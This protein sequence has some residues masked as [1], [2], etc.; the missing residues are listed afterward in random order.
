MKHGTISAIVPLYNAEKFVEEAL[1]SILNQKEVTV[2]EIIVVDDGSTD[3][4]AKI[5]SSFGKRVRLL[6]QDHRGIAATRNYG[7]K[8]SIGDFIA[9]LDADD[10][11]TEN[12]LL[13]LIE[14]FQTNPATVVSFG[15]VEQFANQKKDEKKITGNQKVL[16][17][18]LPGSVLIRKKLF[19]TVGLFDTSF[20]I[21]EFLEWYSRITNLDFPV[22]MIPEVVLKRRI[23]ENN[24]GILQKENRNDYVR[25]LFEHLK[26]KRALKN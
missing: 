10:I 24:T 12:H 5:V 6:R 2:D 1:N 21:G 26:R 4:G 17:G 11:W 16:H 19:K 9:F 14:P 8:N 20:N 3:K 22:E 23:H 7:I 13:K 25:V 15:R 18:L